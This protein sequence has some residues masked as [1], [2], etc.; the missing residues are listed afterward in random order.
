M[1]PP[2]E[3]D[4]ANQQA[5]AAHTE[6]VRAAALSGEPLRIEGPEPMVGGYPLGSPHG[7]GLTLYDPKKPWLFPFEMTSILLLIAV[8]GSVVLARRSYG[9]EANK[10]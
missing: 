6:K 3:A 7:I 4:L 10:S 8:I 9:A 2:S 1:N 5:Q